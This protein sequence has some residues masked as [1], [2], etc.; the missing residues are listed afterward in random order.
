MDRTPLK[1]SSGCVGRSALWN[2]DN[3]NWVVDMAVLSERLDN[4]TW[5]DARQLA[6]EEKKLICLIMPAVF[7]CSLAWL[8]QIPGTSASPRDYRPSRW[9][10]VDLSKR[11]VISR[12]QC[13]P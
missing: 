7:Y 9:E 8:F 1:E 12:D 2:R 10:G 11:Y 13:G 4:Q 3:L 5:K 6:V